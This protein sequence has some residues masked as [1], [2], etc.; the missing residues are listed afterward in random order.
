MSTQ[1]SSKK[2]KEASR[3][4]TKVS[5]RRDRVTKEVLSGQN[6]RGDFKN[7]SEMKGYNRTLNQQNFGTHKDRYADLVAAFGRGSKKWQP[8]GKKL[9][10][11]AG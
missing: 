2:N 1:V 5:G 6:N 11:S 10:F 3:G 4:H 8:N 9:S 7:S